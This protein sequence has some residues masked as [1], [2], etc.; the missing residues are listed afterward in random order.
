MPVPYQRLLNHIQFAHIGNSQ[1][2]LIILYL[3][4]GGSV[5]AKLFH[6]VPA[7]ESAGVA[8]MVAEK[9]QVAQPFVSG[10]IAFLKN[11]DERTLLLLQNC[12]VLVNNRHQREA[13]AAIGVLLHVAVLLFQLIRK[14]AVIAVDPGNVLSSGS[15]KAGIQRNADMLVLFQGNNPNPGIG[16]GGEEFR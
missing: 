3:H 10:S 13:Y 12:F 16:I 2:V 5:R 15:G 8:Q 6:N 4:Q 1:P 11:G 7:K 14:P 9:K